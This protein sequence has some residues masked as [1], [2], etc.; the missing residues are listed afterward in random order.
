MQRMQ[1]NAIEL[2]LNSSKVSNNAR[3]A[4]CHPA[5]KEKEKLHILRT[6][7]KIKQGIEVILGIKRKVHVR[8]F[9]A[10]LLCSCLI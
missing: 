10:F 2:L 9:P 6:L 1:I 7:L 3:L 5:E 8:T 4:Y